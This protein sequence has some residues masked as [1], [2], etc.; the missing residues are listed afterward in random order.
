MFCFMYY[1]VRFCHYS[2]SLCLDI[3][4]KYLY[5]AQG[6]LI[7]KYSSSWTVS[8]SIWLCNAWCSLGTNIHGK[9]GKKYWSCDFSFCFTCKL[10]WGSRI[11]LC[12]LCHEG[13]IERE[14]WLI[15]NKK[16]LS[17]SKIICNGL[18]NRGRVQLC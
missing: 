1:P 3:S 17:C 16:P 13:I 8:C 5:Y 9:V 12:I 4:V 15:W 7:S 2:Y 18:L 11:G 10:L 6:N 14:D